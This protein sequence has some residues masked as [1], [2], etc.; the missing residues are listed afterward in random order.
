MRCPR[1]FNFTFR[2]HHCRSCGFVV[3]ANCSEHIAVIPDLGYDA[4]VR[5][6]DNCFASIKDSRVAKQSKVCTR[7][8]SSSYPHTYFQS[9][10]MTGSVEDSGTH[11]MYGFPLM[12]RVE[13]LGFGS[14]DDLKTKQE[15][16]DELLKFDEDYKG[17]LDKQRAAWN[18]YLALHPEI[19]KSDP[20]LKPL[21]RKGIPPELRGHI[22]QV[23]S[24]AQKKRKAAPPGYYQSLLS[25]AEKDVQ[26]AS[27]DIE[28]DL[29]R[30]FPNHAVYGTLEG[31]DLLRRVLLAYSVHNKIVGYW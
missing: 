30:T 16:V 20:E 17:V 22:W 29:H 1:K 5:V 19:N 6:C 18:K 27:S 10:K 28:K 2:K 3:C 31:V 25:K 9:A 23:I 11:D 7:T 21:V 15:N 4:P 12:N 8:I 24:G 14:R 26:S 13:Q